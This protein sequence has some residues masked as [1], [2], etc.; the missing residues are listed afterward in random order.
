MNRRNVDLRFDSKVRIGVTS[1]QT[2]R[3]Q[4]K[5]SALEHLKERL[6][7]EKLREYPDSYLCLRRAAEEAASLAWITPCPLLVLPVLL[8]EKLDQANRQAQR[9][10]E[11]RNRSRAIMVLAA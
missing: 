3:S 5:A 8:A 10:R 6:L 7:E 11:I 2:A 9:Q 4:S 1:S